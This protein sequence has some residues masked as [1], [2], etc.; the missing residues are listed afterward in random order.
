M[1]VLTEW[2]GNHYHLLNIKMSY[3]LLCQ[4]ALR[5]HHRE[6]KPKSIYHGQENIYQLPKHRFRTKILDCTLIFVLHK[7]ASD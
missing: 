5:H 1:S 2:S 3:L 4:P 6:Y 7:T